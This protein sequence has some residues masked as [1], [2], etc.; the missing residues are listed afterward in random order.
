MRIVK[1]SE[2]IFPNIDQV[3]NFFQ[4]DLKIDPIGKFRFT[5]GRIS[6][7]A[8]QPNE[9]IFFSYKGV[10]C[11]KAVTITGRQNNV[12]SYKHKYPYY[13]NIDIDTICPANI[14]L[15]ELEKMYTNI[16]KTKISLAHTQGWPI[17]GDNYISEKIWI[18]I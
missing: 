18:L 10:I 9:R 14:K 13:F 12:D 16:S 2:E 4:N 15:H 1:L 11:Y 17:I 6:A 3:H 5:K 8:L 7:K